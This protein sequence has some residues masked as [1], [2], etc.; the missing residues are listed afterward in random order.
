MVYC[1]VCV[2]VLFF[3]PKTAYEMRISDWSS[4]VCSSDLVDDARAQRWAFDAPAPLHRY[5]AR[6]GSI[7]VD[8]VSLTVNAIDDSGFEVALIPHTIEHTAFAQAKAG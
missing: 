7:C 3:K 2:F 4:D 6:K 1:V 8:G 5:I